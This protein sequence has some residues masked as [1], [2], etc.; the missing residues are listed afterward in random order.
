MGGLLKK[1]KRSNTEGDNPRELSDR[2]LRK[3]AKF[4]NYIENVLSEMG[5][6]EKAEVMR[7]FEKI[8]ARSTT[9]KK[10]ESNMKEIAEE[11]NCKHYY[12]NNI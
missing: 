12:I 4:V 2:R 1:F 10:Y 7:E 3:P 8:R 9:S 11:E 6:M 5:D